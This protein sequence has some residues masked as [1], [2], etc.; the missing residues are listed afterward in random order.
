MENLALVEYS[1]IVS[2]A[3]AD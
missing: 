1:I 2:T 3:E